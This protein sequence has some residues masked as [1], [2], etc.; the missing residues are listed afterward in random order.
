MGTR[1]SYND[2]KT[3]MKISHESPL[4][5]LQASRTYNDY[6]YALVHKFE[7]TPE[8]YN[9]FVE[10]LAQ[11]RHVL[12]DNSIFELGTAFDSDRYAYWIEKLKPTEYIIPDVLEDS[13]GT[14]TNALN[15]AAKY[16]NLPGKKIG[17]V[18]GE[19]YEDLLEC[20]RFMDN[21]I[22]VDKIAISFDYSYYEEVS[23]HPNKWMSFVLGR[24]QTLNRLLTDGIINKNKPHHLLGC[25]LPIEFMFYRDFDWIDTIDTSSPI[26]HGLLGIEYEPAGL[27]TKQ[28]IK[29]VDLMQSVPDQKQMNIINKNISL[30]RSYVGA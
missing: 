1:I 26:V 13:A 21:K 23:P 18:Q 12:L 3:T 30:F 9:F 28:S 11:G 17:V 2:R 20:Y 27:T 29:L 4:S 5:M 16:H 8:Y 10:S 22:N 14:M 7:D 25:A 15:F 6:D 24:V 19:S